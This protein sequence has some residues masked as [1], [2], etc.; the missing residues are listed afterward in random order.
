MKKIISVKSLAKHFRKVIA[1]DGVS[2][3]VYEGEVFALLGPNGAGKT[4]TINV[5]TTLLK[6][7]S[8]SATVCG[9]DVARE[10]R[11]VRENI[12]LLPQ[13]IVLENN[14]TGFENLMFH[15]RLYH[16]KRKFARQRADELLELVQL[17]KSADKWSR[18]RQYK[19]L[20]G[21]IR[22]PVHGNR[23]HY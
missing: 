3:N 20:C 7:T 13:E 2:F 14:L 16:L 4:T 8:G 17:R 11:R 19:N 21:E 12:G 6:P 5:L 15:S 18:A 1:V 23:L 22:L 10:A 9:S